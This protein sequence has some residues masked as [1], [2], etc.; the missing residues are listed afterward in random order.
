MA[1]APQFRPRPLRHSQ[2]PL[3]TELT[4]GLAA[5]ILLI[6]GRSTHTK[7]CSKLHAGMSFKHS[8]YGGTGFL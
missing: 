2:N 1:D 4:P 7:P 8:L 3:L 5:E 6:C